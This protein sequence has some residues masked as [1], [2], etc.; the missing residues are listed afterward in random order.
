MI[1]NLFAAYLNISH[2]RLLHN[3]HKQKIIYK[4]IQWVALFLT[5][6]Y[7]IVK[8]N[9]HITLKL[10]IDL[11]LRQGSPLLS[12]FYLFYNADLLDENA[13]KKMEA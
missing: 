2:Q 10:F 9:K 8:T 3:L 7:T 12:I 13:K 11:G 4:V 5:N 6:R 1:I